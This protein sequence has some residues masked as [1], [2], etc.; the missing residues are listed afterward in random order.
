M[1]TPQ[2][3]RARYDEQS[4]ASR[5]AHE[6]EVQRLAASWKSALEL[7]IS[8]A[9]ESV[10]PSPGVTIFANRLTKDYDTQ[11]AWDAAVDTARHFKELG[12]KAA[13]FTGRSGPPS[14]E[15]SW[16]ED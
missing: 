4:A 15:V 3:M 8:S 6:I 1:K 12:F 2:E 10:T 13:A 7:A 9:F 14:V 16:S 11:A 5:R